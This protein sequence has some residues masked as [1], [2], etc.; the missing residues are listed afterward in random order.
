MWEWGSRLYLT[1]GIFKNQLQGDC[2]T[3]V[4]PLPGSVFCNRKTTTGFTLVELLVVISIISFLSS[5]VLASLNTARQKAKITAIKAEMGEFVK[6]LEI[7]RSN[8][9]EYLTVNCGSTI[10]SN[11]DAQYQCADS[12]PDLNDPDMNSERTFSNYIA[13][14]SNMEKIYKGDLF[15]VLASIPKVSGVQI[16]YI[17]S[18]NGISQL[19]AQ[20]SSTVNCGG[21]TTAQDYFMLIYVFD[22]SG[23]PITGLES[24][25]WKKFNATASFITIGD[26]YLNPNNLGLYCATG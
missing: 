23:L 17:S 5:I 19:N 22:T 20:L 13:Y 21:K 16:I 1:M 6:A 8:Y 11:I 7:Y 10:L 18:P 14:D 9:G 15:E 12:V 26:S 3:K 2:K 24:T 4:K 25:Y